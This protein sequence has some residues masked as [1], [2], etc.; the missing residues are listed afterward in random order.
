MKW[1]LGQV[2]I[3]RMGKSLFTYSNCSLLCEVMIVSLFVLESGEVNGRKTMGFWNVRNGLCGNY[4]VSFFL[5][6]L[7][8]YDYLVYYFLYVQ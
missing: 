5:I 1:N 7:F 2:K 3:S 6:I 4:T 8:M